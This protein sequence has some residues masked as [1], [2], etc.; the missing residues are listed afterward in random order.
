VSKTTISARADTDPIMMADERFQKVVFVRHGVAR[1]NIVGASPL[2]PT[3][4]DPSLV[5]QGKREALDAGHKLQ[6]WWR[7]TQ[8]NDVELVITSVSVQ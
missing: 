4:V 7:A 3:L 6:E 2:D 8:Q 5:Y 1:H